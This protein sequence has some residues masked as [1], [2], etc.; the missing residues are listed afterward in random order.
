MRSHGN[1]FLS[2][3]QTADGGSSGAKLSKPFPKHQLKPLKHAQYRGRPSFWLQRTRASPTLHTTEWQCDTSHVVTVGKLRWFTQHKPG[4][5][6]VALKQPSW[7]ILTWPGRAI[8]L[9]RCYSHTCPHLKRAADMCTQTHTHTHTHTHT[10]TCKTNKPFMGWSHE[11]VATQH[12]WLFQSMK[13]WQVD[14]GKNS[15]GSSIWCET[16]AGL[17][18]VQ[19]VISVSCHVMFTFEDG[20]K[21]D[22]G[23]E[24]LFICLCLWFW[25]AQLQRRRSFP[26]D[27]LKYTEIHWKMLLL[28]IKGKIC[29]SEKSVST[30]SPS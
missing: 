14:S 19:Y 7:C 1:P 16:A 4:H 5:T 18:P 21:C 13:L 26:Q 6:T 2:R 10:Y 9:P 11:H 8:E 30:Y 3:P 27:T 25:S 23:C 24:S 29:R 12:I 28:P 15:D 17:Q 22:T 20:Y